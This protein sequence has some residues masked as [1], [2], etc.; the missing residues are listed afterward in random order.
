MDDLIY[1]VL[2]NLYCYENIDP[3]ECSSNCQKNP[4]SP[5]YLSQSSAED[6]VYMDMKRTERFFCS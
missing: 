3:A 4:I 6:L 5:T 2:D 1:D